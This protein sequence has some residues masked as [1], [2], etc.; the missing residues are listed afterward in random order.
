MDLEGRGKGGFLEEVMP[1][2]A[3]SYRMSR[4]FPNPQGRWVKL[5]TV[6]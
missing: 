5:G 4:S 1:E 2:Q 3:G 6:L